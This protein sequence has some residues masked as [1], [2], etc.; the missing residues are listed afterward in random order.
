M[1]ES[2]PD[3]EPAPETIKLTIDGKEIEYTEAETV[4]TLKLFNP[5]E[6]QFEA[7]KK[8]VTESVFDLS[9]PKDRKAAGSL[10]AKITSLRT[11]GKKIYEEWN[12]PRLDAAAAAREFVK[13]WER[14]VAEIEDPLAKQIEEFDRQ[15]REREAREKAEK[16]AKDNLIRERIAGI[17]ALAIQNVMSDSA[18]LEGLVASLKSV[19]V[20]AEVFGEFVAQAEQSRTRALVALEQ[21]RTAALAREEQH[22]QL[23]QQRKQDELRRQQEEEDRQKRQ[24]ELD[25]QAEQLRLQQQQ[26]EEQRKKELDDRAKELEQQRAETVS[27]GETQAKILRDHSDAFESE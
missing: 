9:K 22:R 8:E 20:T 5:I 12:R 26:V 2:A 17:D 15:E 10:R 3:Q 21:L 27:H 4:N 13:I 24:K 6:A 16:E 1:S 7:L 23:E 11:A 25:D 14:K 19:P 18:T